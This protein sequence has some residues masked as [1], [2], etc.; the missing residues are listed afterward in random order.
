MYSYFLIQYN[1]PTHLDDSHHVLEHV[2]SI[3]AESLEGEKT[4]WEYADEILAEK[5]RHKWRME[6]LQ[7]KEV[8]VFDRHIQDTFST[9]TKRLESLKSK[10][11]VTEY[12]D[13]PIKSITLLNPLDPS[14]TLLEW[15]LDWQGSLIR[16]FNFYK[17]NN[18]FC[19]AATVGIEKHKFNSDRTKLEQPLNPFER[20]YSLFMTWIWE[21]WNTRATIEPSKIDW[22][23]EWVNSS[24]EVISNFDEQV[25]KIMETIARANTLYT[26]Q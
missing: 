20:N 5:A 15:H 14:E 18:K 7:Q 23:A 25:W 1:M 2:S 21:W 24:A 4:P 9:L 11:N 17:S 26:V 13:S 6:E 10:G 19:Y 22:Q 8:N 3:V 12:T 16:I